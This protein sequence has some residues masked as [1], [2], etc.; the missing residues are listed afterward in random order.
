[1]N[2]N[3]AQQ[4]YDNRQP[5]DNSII[6]DA[7]EDK[8]AEIIERQGIDWLESRVDAN[9]WLN[10]VAA[11]EK[12]AQEEIEQEAEDAEWEWRNRFN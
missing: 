2:I 9:T 12:V 3:Y 10:I 4:Q 6:D 1:M 8:T 7:T 11:C 5:P